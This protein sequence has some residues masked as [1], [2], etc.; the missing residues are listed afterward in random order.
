VAAGWRHSLGLKNDGSIVAWGA[1][2]YGECTVPEPNT[3]FTAIVADESFSLGLK[4][5]GSIVGWGRNSYGECTAP[6]PN[7]G[8]AAMAVGANHGLGLKNS[9]L[10]G[11]CH[12]NGHCAMTV[13]ELCVAPAVW[14]G[15]GTVCVPQPCLPS[16]VGSFSVHGPR[17]VLSPNPTFGVVSIDLGAQPTSSCFLEILDASGRLI[18]RIDGLSSGAGARRLSWDGRDG[19]GRE[20]PSGVYIVRATTS[21]G[22]RAKT[23]VR[24]R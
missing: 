5:D 20:A 6:E 17:L 8:F 11:C 3:G 18:R 12:A 21:E 14:Q 16:A 1:N 4:A 10:G 7:T 19:R 23:L 24:A 15:A 13:E 22:V 2:D 9:L